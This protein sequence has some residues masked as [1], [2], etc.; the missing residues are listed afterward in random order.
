[1]SHVQC[2]VVAPTDGSCRCTGGSAY[3]PIGS[4]GYQPPN[5]RFAS[6]LIPYPGMADLLTGVR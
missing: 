2:C 6:H 1:M 3:T 5:W 4:R